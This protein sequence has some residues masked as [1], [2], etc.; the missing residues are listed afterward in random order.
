MSHERI[1][2]LDKMMPLSK[3]SF[4]LITLT[5][6]LSFSST[7]NAFG[8]VNDQL[9]DSIDLYDHQRFKDA[10]T[11][12]L[13]LVKAKEF[14]RLDAT[15][16][17]LALDH[18]IFSL[19][20]QGKARD[21]MHYTKPLLQ[22]AKS[23][24]GK[25]SEQYV[26]ALLTKALVQY[27]AGKSSDAIRSA[28]EMASVLERLGDEYAADLSNAR[29]I[30][31]KIRK[32][33]WNKKFLPKDLSDFYTTCEAIQPGDKLPGVSRSMHEYMLVGRDF[34]P[35]GRLK[36]TFRNTYIKHAKENSTDRANRLVYIPDKDHLDH[37]CVVY[38]NGGEVDRAV[39]SP[40]ED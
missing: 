26:D 15:E 28:Q 35:T 39:T 27:R 37:W 8:N 23:A 4:L 12:L 18:L 24:F 11:L 25:H 1:F 34:R 10:A 33:E 2:E 21:A 20:D 40:P 29:L 16:K 38:P 32:R 6:L 5:T 7:V 3:H 9:D 14:R 30:P 36:K 13:D 31:G 17:T 19:I 22:N